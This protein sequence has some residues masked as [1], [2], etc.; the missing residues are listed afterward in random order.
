MSIFDFM[1]PNSQYIDIQL[2][3]AENSKLASRIEA[4]SN[5]DPEA[6]IEQLEQ[7]VGELAL[8]CKTLMRTL[9][10]KRVCTGQEIENLF[11]QID[12]EDGV[13]DGKVTR[14]DPNA[15]FSM[16]CKSSRRRTLD[17]RTN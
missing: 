6:R 8:V 4:I 16:S 7:E 15:T 9:L 13:A 1:F 14:T 5:S 17:W 2:L 10:E 3:K 11:K 12:L